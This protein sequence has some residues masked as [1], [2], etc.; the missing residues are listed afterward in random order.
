MAVELP[1]PRLK[2]VDASAVGAI[3][4]AEPD[5]EAAASRMEGYTL[6]APRLLTFELANACRKKV[7]ARP[8]QAPLLYAGLERLK[9]FDLRLL[10]VDTTA[11]A[12]LAART[13]L[14]AYDAAYLWLSRFLEVELVTLDRRLEEAS[15]AA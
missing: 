12:M 6:A 7:A 10:A 14:S 8:E 11:T 9:D 3:L 4:F 13:G 15:R 2:V 5:S 1:P